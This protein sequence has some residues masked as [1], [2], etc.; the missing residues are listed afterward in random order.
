MITM[1]KIFL[2]LLTLFLLSCGEGTVEIGENTYQP[3]I[4]VEGYLVP[5]KYVEGIRITKNFPINSKPNP[6]SILITDALVKI[7]DLQTSREY[8]LKYNPQK[9]SYESNELM[10]DYDKSYK[11]IVEANFDGEKL[12]TTGITHTPK[13]GFKIIREESILDSLRYRE[14]DDNSNLKKFK[15]AFKP[16]EGT[17]FYIF[18]LAAQN[19]SENTFIFDNPYFDIK[20]EDLKK[21]FDYYRYRALWIENINSSVDKINYEIE[22]FNIWFYGNYR[23]IV[24]AGDENFRL[25]TLTYRNIQEQDG[26]FHEPRLNLT[27]DGIGIFGSYIADTVY[28][29]VLK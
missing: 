3:K 1:K 14:M 16:S 5:G 19:A 26:N 7:I 9:F 13:Y 17:G 6:M 12:K 8:N 23:L 22:W 21:N 27:D 10:I 15:I 11:L 20:I 29:K 24:Y 28:I 25:F 2:I 18:S 4:V